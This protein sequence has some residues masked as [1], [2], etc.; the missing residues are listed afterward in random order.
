MIFWS[1]F[2]IG[3]GS[4]FL[5]LSAAIALAIYFEWMEEKDES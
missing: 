5:F 4:A 3:F 1:G 2:F